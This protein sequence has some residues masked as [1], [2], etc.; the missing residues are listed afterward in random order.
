MMMNSGKYNFGC[1]FGSSERT[2]LYKEIGRLIRS[3]RR[4]LGITEHQ[5]ARIMNVSQQQVSRYERGLNR[6]DLG[7]LL[8]LSLILNI[9]EEELLKLIADE[10]KYIESRRTISQ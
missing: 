7:R 3:A 8:E 10:Y 4:E 1:K 5:L 2:E 9:R 6:I